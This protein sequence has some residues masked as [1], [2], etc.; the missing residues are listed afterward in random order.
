MVG[1][2]NIEIFYAVLNGYLAFISSLLIQPVQINENCE[3]ADLVALFGT[4]EKPARYRNT[5]FSNP[6]VHNNIK[7]LLPIFDKGGLL[8]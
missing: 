7:Q 6:K 2:L 4:G 1:N 8:D 3:D 5:I